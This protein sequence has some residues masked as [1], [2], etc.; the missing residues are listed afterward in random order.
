M[1]PDLQAAIA[2][3]L[4][5]HAQA[6][7][8]LDTEYPERLPGYRRRYARRSP[9]NV[10]GSATPYRV[11][12]PKSTS[13]RSRVLNAGLRLILKKLCPVEPELPAPPPLPVWDD[14]TKTWR[15]PIFDAKT[16]IAELARHFDEQGPDDPNELF[17]EE[18]KA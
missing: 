4:S 9:G 18:E 12:L 15:V 14:S 1:L 11:S 16:R 7:A 13:P 3:C 2:E 5:L 6:V 17:R 8:K 10:T